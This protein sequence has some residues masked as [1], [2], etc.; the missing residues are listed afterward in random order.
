M[1]RKSRVNLN[2][3]ELLEILISKSVELNRIPKTSDI[4]YPSITTFTYRFG[5]WSNALSAAGLKNNNKRRK[6]RL[7]YKNAGEDDIYRIIIDWSIKNKRTPTIKDFNKDDVLPSLSIIKRITMRTWNEVLQTLNLRINKLY[8]L[9]FDKISETKI[10]DDFKKELLK[11][12]TT[13]LIKYETE[14][15]RDIPSYEY[16]K[17]RFNKEWKDLLKLVDIKLF[18]EK[19]SKQ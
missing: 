15:S 9:E 17:I 19:L 5:S 13:S 8:M 1:Q 4:L 18:S 12:D 16:L 6:Y 11:L 7:S 10:L 14:R 3:N 2:D